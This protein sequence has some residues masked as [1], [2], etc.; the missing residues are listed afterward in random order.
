MGSI[1]GALVAYGLC[2]REFPLRRHHSHRWQRNVFL[3]LA[4]DT[5]HTTFK[6]RQGVEGD[7]TTR[8]TH[9]TADVESALVPTLVT[10]D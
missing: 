4:V 5:H 6:S 2:R 3:F 10:L 1:A 8:L 9:E 7:F